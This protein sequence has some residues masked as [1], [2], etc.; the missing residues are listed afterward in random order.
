MISKFR[1]ASLLVAIPLAASDFW[2]YASG[3]FK[4]ATEFVQGMST[5]AQVAV[6]AF[7]AL[8]L[9]SFISARIHNKA[10]IDARDK[11]YEYA[12]PIIAVNEAIKKKEE[13]EAAAAY[14][15]EAAA[16]IAPLDK[17]AVASLV[18]AAEG[19]ASLGLPAN[20]FDLSGKKLNVQP[21]TE[22]EAIT[23]DQL[24]FAL[25]QRDIAVS[26]LTANIQTLGERLQRAQHVAAA[27]RKKLE[28]L[29]AASA[30]LG[31][32]QSLKDALDAKE[33]EIKKTEQALAGLSEQVKSLEGERGILAKEKERIS[34][35]RDGF[36][37]NSGEKERLLVLATGLLSER[38][39]ELKEL[40]AQLAAV[41]SAKP[42]PAA[43]PVSAVIQ[44]PAPAVAQAPAAPVAAK[45]APAPKEEAIS[46][47]AAPVAPAAAPEPLRG[48]PSEGGLPATVTD[49]SSVASSEESE[50]Y[51]PSGPAVSV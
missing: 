19:V 44:V 39:K 29:E 14:E 8:T 16:I 48:S 46:L 18:C 11:E 40:K 47:G 15:K 23:L 9:S 35:E 13:A 32:I 5:S 34:R 7:L 12:A 37:R 42:E 36:E 24:I 30:P 28:S 20:V 4:G 43:A 31:G 33:A 49:S 22:E 38:E 51:R 6:G 50:D 17:S 45:E 2:T 3:G 10:V 27:D 1:G 21:K 41:K 25:D 26:T